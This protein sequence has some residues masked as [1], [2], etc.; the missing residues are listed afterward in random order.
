MTTI[1][2]P[3]TM[4]IPSSIPPVFEPQ[5]SPAPHSRIATTKRLASDL[6]T[7]PNNPPNRLRHA[8]NRHSS[9]AAAPH[10]SLTRTTSQT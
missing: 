1:A 10:P 9:P 6:A 4:Q 3:P 2:M 8:N 7:A 5:R